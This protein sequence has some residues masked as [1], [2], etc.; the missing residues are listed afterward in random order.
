MILSVKGLYNCRR[1]YYNHYLI[2]CIIDTNVSSISICKMCFNDH[3]VLRWWCSEIV[4]IHQKYRITKHKCAVSLQLPLL[5]FW[6]WWID[7]IPM[8]HCKVQ[9]SAIW[10]ISTANTTVLNICKPMTIQYCPYLHQTKTTSMW[11]KVSIIM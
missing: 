9:I 1:V 11:K 4:C 10:N 5:T 6:H 8:S 7:L 2:I 3:G